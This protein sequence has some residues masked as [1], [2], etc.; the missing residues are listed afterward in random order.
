MNQPAPD[1]PKAS[2]S[3]DAGDA[4][5]ITCEHGGHGVPPAY[6]ALFAGHEELLL[7]H[8]GWDMGALEMAR[9]LAQ[10]LDAPLFAATTTRLLIDLNRSIG[11]RQLYSEVTRG[12]PA[13]IRRDIIAL[14]YQPHRA[15]VESAVARLIAR[16]R[17]VLH[18][19]AH[20]F[21]PE[22]HGVVRQADV[23]WLYDPGRAGEIIAARRWRQTLA[24]R[25][26]DL[27]LRRNYPYQ[28]KCDGLTAL[29]RK[30]HGPAQYVGIELEVNQRFAVEGGEAWAALQADLV[31]SLA[32]VLAVRQ[33]LA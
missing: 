12:L 7:T 31:R 25:R 33:G 2:G 11:H 26:P 22:L 24:Q 6:A 28:G 18:I 15:A 29:L 30:R 21:T 14:H 16:G 27:A 8:R 17:R 20:S 9:Q 4:L 19:A 1:N 32:N 23:A 10:A 3:R 5:V 13:A